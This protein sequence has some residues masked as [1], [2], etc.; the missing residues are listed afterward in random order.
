MSKGQG[1]SCW[2][3]PDRSVYISSVQTP[4]TSA[5]SAGCMC[6]LDVLVILCLLRPTPRATQTARRRA[7]APSRAARRRAPQNSAART[8]QLAAAAA[9]AA[10]FTPPPPPP[11]RMSESIQASR[12]ALTSS[13][14]SSWGQWPAWMGREGPRQAVGAGMHSDA[15][16]HRTQARTHNTHTST[17]TDAES[18]RTQTHKLAGPRPRKAQCHNLT[19]RRT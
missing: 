4:G 18:T 7:N 11:P 1:V 8:R 15:R 10:S 12:A 3:H 5:L 16:L 2:Q 17:R 14:R 6:V 19:P 9:A 13:G